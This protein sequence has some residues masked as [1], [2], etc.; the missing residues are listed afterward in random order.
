M[1]NNSEEYAWLQYW[2]RLQIENLFA[3]P[4]QVPVLTHCFNIPALHTY[5]AKNLQLTFHDCKAR[6]VAVKN[7]HKYIITVKKTMDGI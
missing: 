4:F 3:F 6:K 5:T 7:L 2:K 1:L